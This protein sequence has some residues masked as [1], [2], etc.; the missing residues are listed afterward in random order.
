MCFQKDRWRSLQCLLWKVANSHYGSEL[1]NSMP[2]GEK[3][4]ADEESPRD[5][6]CGI[7]SSLDPKANSKVDCHGD[8]AKSVNRQ[9]RL[10]VI[11]SLCFSL[12]VE[13]RRGFFLVTLVA[14]FYL[15]VCLLVSLTGIGVLD[16]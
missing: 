10:L 16:W 7:F 2:E 1:A 15:S 8:G 9:W 4:F 13:V 14:A 5:Q 3:G 12:L 11:R 6:A